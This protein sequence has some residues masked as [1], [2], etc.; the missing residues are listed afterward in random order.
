VPPHQYFTD[1]AVF[2]LFTVNK[3]ER[4]H[5]VNSREQDG[6]TR[7]ADTMTII[8]HD[9]R[10]LGPHQADVDVLH[11]EPL[12]RVEETAQREKPLWQI[13]ADAARKASTAPRP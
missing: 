3:R 2:I 1:A 12:V 9:G 11:P 10:P 8:A 5:P 7:R 13:A 4:E 6:P